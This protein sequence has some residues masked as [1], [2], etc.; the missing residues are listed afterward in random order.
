MIEMTFKEF[1]LRLA[2]E[3]KAIMF[4]WE[5]FIE[6]TSNP[7]SEPNMGTTGI[8]FDSFCEWNL[9]REEGRMINI[10]DCP[11]EMREFH[12]L[13]NQ[14]ENKLK[15]QLRKRKSNKKNKTIEKDNVNKKPLI[16]KQ[17]IVDEKMLIDKY[18]KIYK[19]EY[20]T[21]ENRIKRFVELEL[22]EFYGEIS[23]DRLLKEKTICCKT[24][25]KKYYEVVFC[26]QML[27]EEG[28]WSGKEHWYLD[29]L[30][31]IRWEEINDR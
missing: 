15:E 26:G 23:D 17:N 2:T 13:K 4:N 6:I 20:L 19:D 21:D 10:I 3:E 24:T 12:R 11:E 8:E 25:D 22:Y 7:T 1:V 31:Y 29:G 28:Q 18:G 9:K 16:K 5:G 14:K 27:R 30:E